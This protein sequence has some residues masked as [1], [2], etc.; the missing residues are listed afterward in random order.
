M[1]DYW[2]FFACVGVLCLVYPPF[3]G[4]VMGCGSLLVLWYIFYLIANNIR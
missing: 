3:L 4:F 1:E 2:K